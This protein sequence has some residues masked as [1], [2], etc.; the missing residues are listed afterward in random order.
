MALLLKWRI[1]RLSY[2]PF[3]RVGELLL[4]WPSTGSKMQLATPLHPNSKARCQWSA[5]PLAD[6]RNN[7]VGI[8]TTAPSAPAFS[9]HK[10]DGTV[11]LLPFHGPC[12]SCRKHYSPLQM[13]SGTYGSSRCL[14]IIPSMADCERQIYKKKS[15]FP[16]PCGKTEY[17]RHV[18]RPRGEAR[19]ARPYGVRVRDTVLTTATGMGSAAACVCNVVRARG[20]WQR[21]AGTAAAVRPYVT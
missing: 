7:A 1:R 17:V 6:A 13:C 15:S 20:P 18:G 19:P 4:R 10:L 8:G 2:G 14:S 5:L 3:L 9:C 21:K 11:L 12:S 16:C